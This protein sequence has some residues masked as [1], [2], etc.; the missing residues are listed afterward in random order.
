MDNIDERVRLAAFDWLSNQT[1]VHGDV[2]PRTILAKGF[3]FEGKRVPL[4]GPQ[5]IFKPQLMP[6][7][8][9]SITTVPS[10]PYDDRS[11]EEGFLL[12]RYRGT[13][14]QHRDNAGLRK[15]MF[16]RT[17]LVYFYG[18]GPG[19]YMAIWPVYI[20]GDFPEKLTF[21][22]AVDDLSYVKSD[23]LYGSDKIASEADESR[24]AYITAVVRQRLHQRSF[25]ERVLQAYRQ[26]C[27]CCRLRHQELLDA[28]HIIPDIDPAGVPEVRNGIALCK[29]HHAAFDSYFLAIR[30]DYI[31]EVRKDIM[32]EEDGPMLMHGLQAL[33][34]SRIVLPTLKHLFPDPALLE[35][36]YTDFCKPVL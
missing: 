25:R 18:I 30:P 12:Y 19:K 16:K 5:G 20:V 22:V 32:D 35:R 1:K 21:K 27:A 34:H 9:L 26:Q 14:P 3:E 10:G 33:H 23:E 8:P 13:D 28:A 4:V 6:E 24:R 11:T 15:A 29:L 17:P 2:I 36:R 31:V 7:I